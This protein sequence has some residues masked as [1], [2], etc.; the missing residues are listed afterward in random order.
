MNG[1]QILQILG[2]MANQ[3]T[4]V[5]QA[6]GQITAIAGA[7]QPQPQPQ[8]AVTAIA[9]AMRSN[10]KPPPFGEK[11]KPVEVD[12]WLFQLEQ[13]FE[14]QP[15]LSEPDKVRLAGLLLHGMAASWYRDM[16]KR[17]PAEQPQTFATFKEEMLAMFMPINRARIARD[18]LSTA[19]QRENEPVELYT[20]Y[21]RK[22]FLAIGQIAEDEKVDR[23]VRGLKF[24]LRKE[25]FLQEPQTFESASRIAAKYDALF[26]SMSKRDLPDIRTTESASTSSSMAE[27]M[28][29]S[30]ISMP[31]QRNKPRQGSAPPDK[32]KAECFN[33]GK[34]GHWARDCWSKP[35]SQPS[36]S[37]PPQKP[38]NAQER[39][40]RP[41]HPR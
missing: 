28:D 39:R 18:K 10:L 15:M 9:Q 25:V 22:L 5:T 13:W 12:T 2:G 1:E 14:T 38:K 19:K 23:Y 6:L 21:M 34:K 4:Q 29:L 3:M 16:A 41:P 24:N 32:S 31:Y 35:R 27:P 11:D 30:G 37:Q 8:P 40:Q 17:P 33:C 7:V 36:N 20:Q 26:R